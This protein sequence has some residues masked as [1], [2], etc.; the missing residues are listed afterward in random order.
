MIPNDF[1]KMVWPS[2]AP[3]SANVSES[4]RRMCTTGLTPQ[5]ARHPKH[6]LLWSIG[7]SLGLFVVL[8]AVGWMRHPPKT[9]LLIASSGAAIWALLQ[10]AVLFVGVGRAPGNRPSCT[11]RRLTVVFVLG[12]FIAHLAYSTSSVLSFDQFLTVHRSV[13]GT[14]VCGIHALLFGAIATGVLFYLWRRTD[15][16]RPRLTGAL[17]GLAGG[18]V[19]GVALDLTCTCLEAWH[20]MLSHGLTLVALVGTGWFAGGKWLHP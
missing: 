18:L 3:P 7:I 20:L 10:A 4:I 13:H 14:V 16:F 9:A 17:M 6:R 5:R 19:G 2:Q 1:D 8:L 12:L 11:L 15:P